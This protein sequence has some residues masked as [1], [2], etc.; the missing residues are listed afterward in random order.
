MVYNY[1]G[2]KKDG[3]LERG[4]IEASSIEDAKVKLKSQGISAYE[5]KESKTEFLSELGL[6]SIGRVPEKKLARLTRDL[7]IFLNSGISI[8]KAIKL[9]KLQ[10]GGDKQIE[11]FLFSIEN[12][13]NEGKSFYQALELQKSINLAEFYK[14]SI[15]VAESR[16]FLKEILVE[17]ST[18]ILEKEKIRAQVRAAFAYP[19]FIVSASLVMLIFMFVVAIPKMSD[20]FA[21]LNQ[22]LPPVTKIVLA[23]SSFMGNNIAAILILLLSSIVGLQLAYKKNL[24][25]KQKFDFWL[26]KVPLFG[27]IIQTAELSR[28]L[29][30]SSMLLRSGL[31]FVQALKY[32]ND[33]VSN[34]HIK[35]IILD[36]TS[37]VVEGQRF[38]VMLSRFEELD[39]G[40][41]QAIYLAEES[42]EVKTAF[43]NL[44]NLYSEEN[45][46]KIALLTSVLE[47]VLILA[48]GG[49]I[50]VVVVAMLLPIF[51]ISIN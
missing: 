50:G 6:F 44:S 31:P 18:F 25:F 42:G 15:K 17:L 32:G 12:S 46:D 14:Q 20:V 4:K 36:A 27:R 3:E 5:L 49:I 7:S 11:K 1:E 38:S 19:A 35:D 8:A 23:I 22:E 10:Y 48:V 43:E 28:F 29:S 16:G 51:S 13:L 45:K 34:A 24:G 33:V 26:L 37:K 40:F 41:V 2:L 30:V 21:S 39:K 9:S 47:P